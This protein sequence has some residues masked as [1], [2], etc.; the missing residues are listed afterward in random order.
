MEQGY[1]ICEEKK[2]IRSCA[3]SK[4]RK[5]YAGMDDL[6]RLR[7]CEAELVTIRD[8]S[9]LAPA[10]GR[11]C[12]DAPE[13]KRNKIEKLKREHTGEVLTLNFLSHY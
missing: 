4:R 5:G 9:E 3:L 11:I 7:F 12:C 8:K 1:D 2:A 6:K 10:K 13:E